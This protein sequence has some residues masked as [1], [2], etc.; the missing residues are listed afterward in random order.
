M[1]EVTDLLTALRTGSMTLEQVAGR[2]RRL[3]WRHPAPP[4]APALA[5]PEPPL[6]DSFEEVVMAYARH[7][8]TDEQ[9]ETLLHAATNGAEPG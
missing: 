7:E 8:L 3:H 1:S 9:Y 4:R 6:P 5:D 2:F